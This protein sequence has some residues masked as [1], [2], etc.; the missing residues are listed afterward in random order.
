MKK[1]KFVLKGLVVF[2]AIIFLLSISFSIQAFAQNIQ[3]EV[4]LD[5]VQIRLS[6]NN[7]LRFIAKVSG[8]PEDYDEVGIIAIPQ[9]L[10]NGE[11]NL[12]TER[13]V[14]IS[15]LDENFK[16]FDI[17]EDSFR[18]T[19]CIIN[20]PYEDFDRSYVVCPYVK[21]TPDGGS[22]TVIYGSNY[23]EYI[24][25]M[26]EFAEGVL[27]DYADNYTED[28]KAEQDIIDDILTGYNK[29]LDSLEEPSSEPEGPETLKVIELNE[30][31]WKIGTL[32]STNGVA[33]ESNNKRIY[34]PVYIPADG[35]EITFDKASGIKYIVMEYD[36][37]KKWLSTSNWITSETYTKRNSQA[38]YYRCVLTDETALTQD[39]IMEMSSHLSI[40]VPVV[41]TYSYLGA[42]AWQIGTLASADGQVS[43][44]APRGQQRI[45]TPEYLPAD[46]TEISFDGTSGVSYLVMEYDSNKN[47]ISSMSFCADTVYSKRKENT[48]FYRVAVRYNDDRNLSQEDIAVLSGCV[49]IK[50]PEEFGISFF[51]TGAITADG[52]YISSDSAAYGSYYIP[53]SVYFTYDTEKNFSYTVS[54]YD[55]GRTFISQTAQISDSQSPEAPENSEYFR[56]TVY[57][58]YKVTEESLPYTG[59]AFT[60]YKTVS[61]DEWA[62]GTI[63]G[64]TGAENTSAAQRLYTPEYYPAGGIKINHNT[65]MRDSAAV[66]YIVLPYDS[67][68]KF[69]SNPGTSGD[70]PK[71]SDGLPVGSFPIE[72]EWTNAAYFRFAMKTGKDMSGVNIAD[73]V[74][75]VDIS[76]PVLQVFEH[77]PVVPMEQFGDEGLAF[78]F[79]HETIQALSSGNYLSGICMVEDELWLFS[80]SDKGSDGYGVALRY[81]LNFEDKSAQYLGYFRHNFGHTNSIDYDNENKCLT[82]GNGSG[83]FSNTA[84]YFYVYK[85]AYEEIKGGADTLELKNAIC[86]DW[87]DCGISYMSKINT[88]W[89]GNKSILAGANNN[90][91]V[92]KIAL[93]TGNRILKYGKA[94]SVVDDEFNGT[95]DIIKSYEMPDNYDNAQAAGFRGQGYDQCNQGTCYADG[96]LYLNCGHDGVYFWRCRL[97]SDGTIKRDEF[98][99]YMIINGKAE[100]SAISGVDRY[101]DYIIFSNGG[102][103]NVYL[104]DMLK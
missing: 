41:S 99:K 29:Y 27:V 50:T 103:I 80:T 73:F 96:E 26:A 39:D 12:D 14:I 33:N 4:C 57:P 10:L 66:C 81:S 76:Y 98:H 36:A 23:D 101:E 20:I 84:N 85:N 49:S 8:T 68:K 86:Y 64:T 77:T 3:P 45:C 90:G 71:S 94:S 59:S 17:T 28:K 89:Y 91:Y 34:T 48:A 61:G 88:C 1:T 60:F 95:W 22:Q 102:Y 51:E 53:T 54:Y 93:G 31:Y 72:G 104:N 56:I 24:L 16:Y 7:D 92:Y 44:A 62:L 67:N 15:N 11:I 5:G 35:T 70:R 55:A 25:S 13:A 46:K 42:D 75:W 43:T 83:D 37:D 30:W 100:T 65:D 18:Y 79:E 32:G 87:A 47:F 69:M 58:G 19:L 52:T 78:R 82:F 97:D 40:K 6:E 63:S 21:Y 2:A 38:A 74:D 9:D